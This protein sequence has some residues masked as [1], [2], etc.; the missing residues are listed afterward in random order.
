MGDFHEKYHLIIHA[1]I[2][3]DGIYTHIP[4]IR[5]HHIIKILIKYIK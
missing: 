1:I 4:S 3:F 2:P 5:T